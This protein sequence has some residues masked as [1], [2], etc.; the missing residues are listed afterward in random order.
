MSSDLLKSNIEKV[1]ATHDGDVALLYLFL[2]N[3]DYNEDKAALALCRTI[4]EVRN[5]YEKLLRLELYN[6]NNPTFQASDKTTNGSDVNNFVSNTSKKYLPSSDNC[7]TY[8]ASDIK[9]RTEEDK[10]FEGIIAEAQR[11]LGHHLSEVDL[12]KLFG[13]YDYLSLPSEVIIELLSFCKERNTKK[14]GT[15]SSL[16]MRTIE[17]EAYE[18]ANQ[19]ILTFE[20]A[21]QYISSYWESQKKLNEIAKIFGIRGRS[22]TTTEQKYITKW[23][24]M[25]FPIETLEIALDRTITNTGKIAWKYMDKIVS[26]WANH[27]AYT[28][29]QV[30]AYESH[31]STI[32]G[33]EDKAEQYLNKNYLK[34]IND[35]I[36]NS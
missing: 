12:Q 32:K 31:G 22:L 9:K 10:E 18:W 36:N 8:T 20:R 16:S 7:P 30:N 3:N 13:I 35:L 5:A 19:D 15:G 26:T 17:R 33:A 24:N 11:L 23:L 2:C 6:I 34:N 1:L 21:E 29:D 25:G 4:N 14:N 27:S 28:P